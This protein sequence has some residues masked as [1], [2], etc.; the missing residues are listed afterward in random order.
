MTD[1]HG[2]TKASTVRNSSPE[3]DAPD[4]TAP[5]GPATSPSEGLGAEQHQARQA[6][7]HRAI[8][9]R[10]S[11]MGSV[12]VLEMAELLGV[13]EATIR[14]DLDNLAT[15]R[16]VERTYGGALRYADLTA[17]AVGPHH[18]SAQLRE[19]AAAMADRCQGTA[20]VAFAGSRLGDQF[21]YELAT[22]RL[23]VLTNS[24]DAAAALSRSTNAELVV[25]GGT[26][27]PGRASLVGSIAEATA[28][29]F[30]VD[31]AVIVADA[32]SR[33]GTSISAPEEA[34]VAAAF[35]ANA[36]RVLIVCPP[37]GIG[38]EAFGLVVPSASIAELLTWSP[39]SD[40]RALGPE[41][42]EV[43]QGLGVP[44]TVVQATASSQRARRRTDGPKATTKAAPAA[45]GS[46]KNRE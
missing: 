12:A 33:W 14:R 15:R 35:C 26:R 39:G 46:Q 44:F 22:R 41:H 17:A 7:R 10:I 32:I 23:A 31:M 27:R 30:H 38:G 16:L 43:L 34:A 25:T 36:R 21:G 29:Q 5:L 37:E 11:G 24:L 6:E 45:V 28:A 3:D 1:A 9:D 19:I 4:E 18:P 42:H 20:S 40:G 13:S 8:L 2:T